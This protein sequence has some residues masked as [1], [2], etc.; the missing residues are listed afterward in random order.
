VRQLKRDVPGRKPVAVVYYYYDYA[1]SRTQK[2]IDIASSLLKQLYSRLDKTS[3]PLL[4]K[5]YTEFLNSG[6]RPDM[7]MLYSVFPTFAP[8]FD[9]IFIFIDALD[10][11]TWGSFA[12][13]ENLFH[14]LVNCNMKL[15][16]TS[17]NVT[18]NFRK[19]FKKCRITAFTPTNYDIQLFLEHALS[20]QELGTDFKKEIID[21]LSAAAQGS[22]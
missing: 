8:E 21:K 5:L 15:F 3:H 2:P 22:Y 12:E 19:K 18:D 16:L 17:R 14:C 1:L 11:Y 20:N 13:V 4:E 6:I 7:E 9:S 10:E